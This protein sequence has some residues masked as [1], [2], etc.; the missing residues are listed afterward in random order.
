VWSVLWAALRSYCV[1][2][3]DWDNHLT[4]IA[5]ALRAS[6]SA[7]SKFSPAM[8]LYGKDLDLPLQ[9]SLLPSSTGRVGV[10][11][12]VRQLLPRL[13][14]TRQVALDNIKAAQQ[15]YKKFYDRNQRPATYE[16]GEMVWLHSSYNPKGVCQK[17]RIKYE[18][19]FYV[20]TRLSKDTYKL[21]NA[22]T[23]QLMLSPV[24]VNRLRLHENHQ[25][26]LWQRFH[27]L[28][29][30]ATSTSNDNDDNSVNQASQSVNDSEPPPHPSTST[31]GDRTSNDVVDPQ[32]D[33][34][35]SNDAPAS[36]PSQSSPVS[37]DNLPAS[38]VDPPTPSS[39]TQTDD[40]RL[41]STSAVTPD[42]DSDSHVQVN[43]QTWF[44]AQR[45]LESKV[46]KGQRLYKIKWDDPKWPA[47]WER[48]RDVS[49]ALK[50]V[51]HLSY[52]CTGKKR[53]MGSRKN[54]FLTYS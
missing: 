8:I 9:A 54:K 52:T 6:P 19:P 45:I 38:S 33:E 5:Y 16:P 50:D 28:M 44:P 49:Q 43:S 2:Q 7:S 29:G 47:S 17:L 20:V 53:K 3:K 30:P 18:G 27:D 31:S 10:D 39:L 34:T 25:D 11:T 4:S 51:F 40:S 32:S 48:D 46:Q 42:Q 37:S 13:Q 1:D 36:Q 26:I 22:K 14:I 15:S 35:A 24:H 41:P 23:N 21:R 12:Y